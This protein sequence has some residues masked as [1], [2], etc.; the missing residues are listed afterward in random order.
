MDRLTRVLT[1]G[2]NMTTGADAGS[3]AADA[4]VDSIL[5]QR[6]QRARR[7]FFQAVLEDDDR[8]VLEGIAAGASLNQVNTDG[9]TPILVASR[10][11]HERIVRILLDA[12][13]P[14]YKATPPSRSCSSSAAPTFPS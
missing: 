3:D 11:G 4:E 13:G 6:R 7:R 8:G 2:W 9:E 5:G 10:L 12:T 1:V 14:W